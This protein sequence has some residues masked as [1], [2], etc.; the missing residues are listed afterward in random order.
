MA[1]RQ[2]VAFIG[3]SCRATYAFASPLLKHHADTHDIVGLYDINPHRM[4]VLNRFVEGSIPCYDDLDAM[5]SEAK[6]DVVLISTVDGSHASYIERTLDHG[7]NCICEKPLCI[8]AEQCHA[9]RAAQKR[10]PEL[11]AVTAH[12]MRY[13]PYIAKVKDLIDSGAVGRPLSFVFQEQLDKR[14]GASY[15]RRWNRRK[16][17]SGGLLIHKASHCFDVMNWWAGSRA[18]DLTAMGSLTMY[19]PDASPFRGKRCCDC[20]H[21][22]KCPQYVDLT[23]DGFRGEMY[24]LARTENSYTPDLCLYDPEIDI[25]DHATVA[26]SYENGIRVTFDLCAYTAHEGVNVI[27]EGTEGKIEYMNRMGSE[28]MKT[29]A[30]YGLEKSFT[31]SIVIY[32]FDGPP[33]RIDVDSASGGHG[34]ADPRMFAD[35]FGSGDPSSARASL[36]DGIQAVLIGVAAN[37]SIKKG[38]VVK[39]QEM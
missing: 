1:G 10:H 11:T 25:E 3:A 20:E 14:H 16:K 26:Y 31:E 36:E 29:G 18:V 5:F 7:V 21:T 13:Q 22:G 37:E 12:N 38:C 33:V 34:G 28:A 4:A 35:L 9:I 8:N 6:P 2:R 17:D 27:I 39:V 32:R 19:G 24:F 23:Q 15:F 30:E